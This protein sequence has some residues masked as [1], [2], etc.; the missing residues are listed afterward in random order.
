MSVGAFRC[1]RVS[2]WYGQV[3]ALADVSFEVGPGVTG[4]LGPNGA[5]KTT[6]MSI[7]TLLLEPT[8]G[9]YAVDGLD[10]RRHAD[11]I[12]GLMG[13][14]PQAFQVFPELTAWEFL[15]Y[16]AQL[17]GVSGRERH[18]QV[19][20][21][22]SR[23]RLHAVRNRRLKTFSGGM[24]RRVG[25]AQALL[26]S[27]RLIIVD[28]P[29]AGLDPEER[30]NLRN[31]LFE[32]G[33]GRIIILSTHIVKDIEE[34]CSQLALLMNGRVEYQG[35]PRAFVERAQGRTWEFYGSAQDIERYTTHPNLVGIREESQG[36]CFRL[37][38]PEPPTGDARTVTPNLEDAY[39]HFLDMGRSAA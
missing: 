19:D 27:P 24:L 15:D 12:R 16:M 38:A 25:V 35:S 10:S 33:E 22:L 9:T 36:V 8:A 14:L 11:A 18:R 37:V 34:T 39:V 28:E 6:L 2:S 17:R 13:Y 3:V 1:E 32:L 31:I 5:G 20:E 30:V 23:V 4:L 21:L 7:L 29:T 26:G